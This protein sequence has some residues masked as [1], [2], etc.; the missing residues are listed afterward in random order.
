MKR[1][2][3]A[4]KYLIFINL[5]ATHKIEQKTQEKPVEHLRM[6]VITILRNEL[7]YKF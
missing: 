7:V 5:P 6:T 3:Y 1:V 2:L 4:I